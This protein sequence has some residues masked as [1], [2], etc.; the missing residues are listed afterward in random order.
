MYRDF[1]RTNSL[2]L[3]R[4]QYSLNRSYYMIFHRSTASP[5]PRN[6]PISASVELSSSAQG[7]QLAVQVLQIRHFGSLYCQYPDFCGKQP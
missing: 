4:L 3:F 1:V 7:S 2:K 5:N 6:V